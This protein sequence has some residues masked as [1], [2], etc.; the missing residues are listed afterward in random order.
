MGREELEP[1]TLRLRVEP[2]G[3][4]LARIGLVRGGEAGAVGSDL[5]SWGHGSGQ[6]IGNA[7]GVA[8]RPGG[9]S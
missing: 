5:P 2:R 6:E 3:V 7:Y 1:S 9:P 4:G 8:E